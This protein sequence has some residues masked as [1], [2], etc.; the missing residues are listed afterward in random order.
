MSILIDY[1]WDPNFQDGYASTS[2]ATVGK[3]N[4]NKVLNMEDNSVK[5]NENNNKSIHNHL[6]TNNVVKIFDNS[7]DT[8]ESSNWAL[9][10]LF[11]N[12]M[13]N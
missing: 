10:E 11:K 9:D 3:S 12:K 4:S 6:N 13:D 2:H 1:V 8:K 7:K 5:I